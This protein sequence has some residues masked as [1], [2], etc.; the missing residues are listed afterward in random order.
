MRTRLMSLAAIAA[1]SLPLLASPATAAP[2][3]LDFVDGD[4]LD[5]VGVG[6]SKGG[7]DG[8]TTVVLTTTDVQA[9]QYAATSPF[10]ATGAMTSAAGRAGFVTAGNTTATVATVSTSQMGINNATISDANG[11]TA[12]LGVNESGNIN[13]NEAWLFKFDRDLTVSQLNFASFDAVDQ[14]TITIG[15]LAPFVLEDGATNDD[16]N[17]P[18]NGLVI[19]AN[20]EISLKNTSTTLSSIVR[21]DALTVAVPEPAT[22]GA[23]AAAGGLFV[24]RRRRQA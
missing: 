16:Y 6:G 23:V 9:P 22:L 14:V 11:S 15:N 2:I 3:V 21:I 4:G 7:T 8:T 5:N 13:Q 20:T 12:G 10:A 1:A 19:P 24:R 18:F 17:D